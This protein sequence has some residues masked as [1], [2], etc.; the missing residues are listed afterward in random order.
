MQ[1]MHI[2]ITLFRR[3][4]R[5]RDSIPSGRYM[6][7]LRVM[8]CKK[9]DRTRKNST[10]YKQTAERGKNCAKARCFFNMIHS[11]ESFLIKY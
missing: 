3:T 5:K 11:Y 6:M 8:L 1:E 2:V 9:D 7:K 10:L 4:T